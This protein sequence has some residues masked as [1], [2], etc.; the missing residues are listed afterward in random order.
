MQLFHSIHKAG[1]ETVI[2]EV[3][4]VNLTTCACQHLAVAQYCARVPTLDIWFRCFQSI[5]FIF[6]A[7]FKSFASLSLGKWTSLV[8]SVNDAQY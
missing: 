6:A 1:G 4:Y 2:D 5:F 7:T 3:V 8:G